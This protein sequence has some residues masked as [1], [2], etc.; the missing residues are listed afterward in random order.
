MTLVT[1]AWFPNQEKVRW[2]D[3]PSN[4][5]ERSN[6]FV[7]PMP[8]FHKMS[9]GE[10][11]NL[12]E[13]SVEV[14][15]QW[16]RNHCELNK[17]VISL[18]SGSGTTAESAL[19]CGRSSIS[20]DTDFTQLNYAYR[21]LVDTQNELSSVSSSSSSTASTSVSESLKCIVCSLFI[22]SEA[23]LCFCMSCKKPIH[24]RSD[25]DGNQCAIPFHK[26]ADGELFVCSIE[27][28][29]SQVLTVSDGPDIFHPVQADF[30]TQE[31]QNTQNVP[32]SDSSILIGEDDV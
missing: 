28:K 16:I 32:L 14:E 23:H 25:D 15:T 19:R 8:K 22:V 2:L 12:T 29:E 9:N 5:K 18:F 10:R 27:C 1:S 20:F 6:V 17:V 3:F 31:S 13:K 7:A 26:I 24:R 30:P 4:A 21:R 11:V